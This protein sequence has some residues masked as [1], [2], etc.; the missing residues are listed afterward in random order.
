[1]VMG[2]GL[3]GQAA[4]DGQRRLILLGVELRGWWYWGRGKLYGSGHQDC[5]RVW[6]GWW[7]KP[8]T[9]KVTFTVSTQARPS[10]TK[11]HVSMEKPWKVT[12]H[13]YVTVLLILLVQ[14][15]LSYSVLS[16]QKAHTGLVK[17]SAHCSMRLCNYKEMDSK[18]LE[19]LDSKLRE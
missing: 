2:W 1:M 17:D 11:D 10:E 13:R 5:T 18:A 3:W 12:R 14:M 9:S 7:V 4:P 15:C 19:M 16:K 6:W 8:C